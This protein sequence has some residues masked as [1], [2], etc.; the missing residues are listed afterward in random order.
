MNA[1]E[2]RPR[3][4]RWVGLAGVLWMATVLGAYYAYNWGYY[5]EKISVFGRHL[6]R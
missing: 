4:P 6:F 3:F 1:P 2:P 5:A